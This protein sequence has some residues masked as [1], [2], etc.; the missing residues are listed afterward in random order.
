[1]ARIS[2]ENF[3]EVA[4]KTLHFAS[5]KFV[6]RG[7]SFPSSCAKREISNKIYLSFF[8]QYPEDREL[9]ARKAQKAAAEVNAKQR[10][11]KPE[12]ETYQRDV[13]FK[14]YGDPALLTLLLQFMPRRARLRVAEA[15]RKQEESRKNRVF[16]D[17]S[18]E[19]G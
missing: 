4:Q 16:K 9:L 3:F 14:P 7:T 19:I 1:M 10:T 13:I 2:S 8:L 18:E 12:V 15:E 6:F 17:L 11:K 5:Q